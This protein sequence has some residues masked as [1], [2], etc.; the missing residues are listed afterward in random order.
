MIT[1]TVTLAKKQLE[2]H[3]KQG[4]KSRLSVFEVARLMDTIRFGHEIE[5]L[6]N[7]PIFFGYSEN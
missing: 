4:S 1:N 5:K 3:A 2:N 7:H 6:G